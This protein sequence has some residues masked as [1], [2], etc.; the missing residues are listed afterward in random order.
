MWS[1]LCVKMCAQQ[2]KSQ[3]ITNITFIFFC[4]IHNFRKTKT[5]FFFIQVT[6]KKI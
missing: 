6:F 4:I 2:N 1:C 3:V 5:D